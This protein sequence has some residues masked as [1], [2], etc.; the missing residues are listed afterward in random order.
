MPAAFTFT[1]K[2]LRVLAATVAGRP[3]PATY[4]LFATCTDPNGED[5]KLLFDGSEPRIAWTPEEAQKTLQALRKELPEGSA[6]CFEVLGPLISPGRAGEPFDVEVSRVS[7]SREDAH[8]KRGNDVR[9]A[10]GADYD[11]LCWTPAAFDKFVAPY[12]YMLWGSNR[13][14]NRQVEELR[15]KMLGSDSGIMGH[16]WPTSPGILE[17]ESFDVLDNRDDSA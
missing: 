15:K 11:L 12:Y 13:E 10:V 16:R 4:Y 6:Q 17:E 9:W 2:F 14:A 1:A 7:S 5:G 8:G 3:E